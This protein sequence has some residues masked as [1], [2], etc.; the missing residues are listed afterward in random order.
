MTTESVTLED[1][2]HMGIEKVPA[3]GPVHLAR[4]PGPLGLSAWQTESPFP[5]LLGG[6]QPGQ[7]S[8]LCH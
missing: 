7:H 2:G 4:L 8:A 5:G 3:G 1:P 6:L